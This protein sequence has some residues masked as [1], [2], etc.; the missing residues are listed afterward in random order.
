M[1]ENL[2]GRNPLF[3]EACLA[4]KADLLPDDAQN[5]VSLLQDRQNW[6]I[7]MVMNLGKDMVKEYEKDIGYVIGRDGKGI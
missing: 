1:G 4:A 5:S 3:R 6:V 7:V 2:P